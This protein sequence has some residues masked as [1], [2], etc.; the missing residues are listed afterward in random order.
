MKKEELTEGRVE[1][2]KGRG[3]KKITKNH[4]DLDLIL[5]VPSWWP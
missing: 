5:K 1:R 4:S 2:K 3:R